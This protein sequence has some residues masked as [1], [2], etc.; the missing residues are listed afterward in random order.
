MSAPEEGG[1]SATIGLEPLT[2]VNAVRLCA[3]C[4]KPFRGRQPKKRFCSDSCRVLACYDRIGRGRKPTPKPPIL[5]T[6]RERIRAAA[7]ALREGEA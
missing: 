3:R 4:H 6:R 7:E 2:T 5:P 1:T